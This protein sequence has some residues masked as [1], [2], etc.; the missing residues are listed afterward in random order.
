[1]IVDSFRNE[2]F[3]FALDII[4]KSGVDSWGDLDK[5]PNSSNFA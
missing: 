1:M 4:F 5:K 3:A 2:Y